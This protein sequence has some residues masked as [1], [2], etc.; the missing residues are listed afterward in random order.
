M[1]KNFPFFIIPPYFNYKK[2]IYVQL[3][4][5]TELVAQF[6]LVLFQDTIFSFRYD[7]P[8]N[9]LYIIFTMN[10]SIPIL[11]QLQNHNPKKIISEQLY[12]KSKGIVRLQLV[13]LRYTIF[14][15]QKNNLKNGLYINFI[16]KRRKQNF[17]P[18]QHPNPKRNVSA[19][20]YPKIKNFFSAEVYSKE[21]KVFQNQKRVT[22]RLSIP[23]PY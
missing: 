2:S 6:R 16:M 10:R 23:P 15:F 1:R 20:L 9:E 5:G 18:L 21:K 8:K 3:Y 4:P 19:R 7:N 22:I 13:K 17:N 11:N 14:L 12:S